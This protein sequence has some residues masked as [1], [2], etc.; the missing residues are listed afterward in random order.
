[1]NEV[2][3]GIILGTGHNGLILQAYLSRCGLKTL[4]VDRAPIPGGGLRTI[5]NPHLPGFRHNPHSF[6][7]R[8]VTAMPWFR[9]LELER[10]GIRYIEPK[11]NV[12]MILRD[13]RALEWWTDIDRTIA[14]CVEFSRRD[15]DELRRLVDEFKPIVEKILRPEAQSPPLEPGL[16]R[17]LLERSA[18]GRRLLEISALSPLEFVTRHF[19]NDVV[20]AGLLFFNGLREVD[21]RLKGF[22]HSIPALLASRPM[23]QMAEGG[24]ARLAQALVEDITKHG[25]EV[26]CGLEL[27]RILV[28]HGRASGI[29]LTTGE[30]IGASGFVVSGLNPQQ[31]FLD[32]MPPEAVPG[33]VREK[34]AQFQYNLLAPLFGLHLALDEPPRYTAANRRRELDEAFMVLIGLERFGQFDEIIAAHERGDLPPPVAWGACPTL[35]DPSQA[36]PGKHTAFLWEKLPYALGGNPSN[37]AIEKELHGSRLLELWRELAPNLGRGIIADQFVLS[38]ADTETTL[39]NMRRGD[40]LVGSFANNQVGYHRPFAGAGCYRTPIPALYLCG[41]STHPGGNITGLCGYNAARVVATDVG[42]RIWWNPPDAEQALAG[43][44]HLNKTGGRFV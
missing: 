11:L 9:D 7:H 39:P 13:G 14:S 10:Q 29:E 33:W 37:W 41:G 18:L 8:A 30:Q 5:D 4:A 44:P 15:A 34:A 21:L 28:R 1:M 43:I 19:E 17:T 22:G 12:A 25:G 40:L 36:P 20:R 3:D 2:F 6:F 27:C 38:P 42:A 35:F 23:A 16:R 31:T 26:R 32:L 24:S